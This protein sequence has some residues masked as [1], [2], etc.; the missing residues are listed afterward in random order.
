MS[1]NDEELLERL[2][3]SGLR[4]DAE[5]RWWHEGQP[6]EHPRL[7]RALHR[8]LDRLDDGRHVVR[9]EG[10]R[11]AH[12]EV[13]DAPYVVRSLRPGRDGEIELL[14]SDGSREP[15]CPSGVCVG[16][17]NALY[18][19]VKGGRFEARLSRPAH[20]AL[21]ARV[22]ESGD[23]FVLVAGGRRWPITTRRQR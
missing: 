7:S 1:E 17:D 10:E 11:Y 15:L 22:E 9:L 2:R 13:D 8:W 4:L 20:Y 14:L 6:V 19:T 23:G 12:V 18:C 5:G 21:A 16:G 3:E